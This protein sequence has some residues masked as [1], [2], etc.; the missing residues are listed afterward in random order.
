MLSLL[1]HN[2]KFVATDFGGSVTFDP[3][4]PNEAALTMSMRAASLMLI[5]EGRESDRETILRTMHDQVL[6]SAKYPEISY[7]CDQARP[8][9]LVPGQFEVTLEG[10]LTLHGVTRPQQISAKLNATASMFRA[11]GEFSV[12]QSDYDIKQVTVAASML[13]VKDE[14]TCTFDIVARR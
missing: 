8:H 7:R 9:A 6:E 10:D 1:G 13:K 11:F 4:A 12:R 5:D 14:L 3:D 2:P